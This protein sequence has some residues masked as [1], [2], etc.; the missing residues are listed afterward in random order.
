MGSILG[1]TDPVTLG[2]SGNPA[3]T[4]TNFSVNPVTP[5]GSSTLTIGNTGAAAA[6]SSTLTVSATSTSGPKTSNVTLNLY[7]AA[8][9]Q[10]VLLTPANGATNVPVPPTFTWA[11][12]AQAGTYSIQIATDAGFTNIVDQASGLTGTT[13]TPS[14]ALNT[15]TLYYWRVLATNACGTSAYSEVFNFRTVAAPGDCAVGTTPNILL[16]EGFEGGPGGWTHS[17]TG[18]SWAI[19][20]ATPHSG[21]QYF[22]ANDPASIT[23]QRLVSPAI[24]LPTGQN[25]VVL[26]FWH[27][28]NLENSGTTAC[29]DGGIVEVTTNGGT[30]WTPVPNANLLVG[31]YT[32]LVSELLRQPAG[33]A[34]RL[35]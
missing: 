35:V 13:Y 17:G 23:D 31:P 10:P 30:T 25:P 27:T 18:D 9:G 21:L 19:A 8:A 20:N 5:A 7:T 34:E 32:G 24:A 1:Y 3:G 28:P 22:H 2:V 16:N 33:R 15:N 4:T 14:T 12:A 11:A 6:G 29:Y 26:K